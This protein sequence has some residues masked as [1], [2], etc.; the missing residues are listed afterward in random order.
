LGGALAAAALLLPCA[1]QAN[2]FYVAPT[3]SDTNTGNITAPFA[4]IMR[5]QTAASANDTVYLRGGNYT[6]NTA[7]VTTIQDS[8]Y[9][10]VNNITKN[11]IH[12]LAY[13]G[14]ARPVF[15]FSQVTPAGTR[16]AAF[17]VTASNITFQGFD[18]IGVQETITGSNNQSIG[19]AIFG[20]SNCTWN[21]VNVHDGMCV[22]FYVEKASANNLFYQCDSYNN[23][24]LDSFSYGNADGFGCHPSAGGTGNVFRQC[25]SWN[26]SDDGYDCINAAEP[27]TFDHCWSYLNGNNGGNANGFKVGGWGSTVQSSIPNPLPAH[28]VKYCLSANNGSHGF[29]ANHQPGQAATWTYNTAFN[30]NYDFDML[31]RTAPIYT[32]STAQTDSNDISG[33][34][35]IMHYNLA[36]EG[37]GGLTNDLNESGAI[38]SNN[39][40]T[41]S[42]TVNSAQFQSVDPTQMTLPRQADGSLPVLT[43][44]HLVSGSNCAG[45]GCFESAPL[46]LNATVSNGQV[47]LTWTSVLGAMAYVVNRSTTSGGNYTAIS[48]NL[49]SGNYTDTTAASGTKYYYVVT[50]SNGEDTSPNSTEVNATPLAAPTGVTA[51]PGNANVTL[52]WTAST[53]ASNYTVQRSTTNGSGYTTLVTGVSATT[54]KDS[55]AANGTT[56]YYIVVAINV[57]GSSGNSTQASGTAQPPAPAA[58]TG[59]IVTPGN[60]NVT[61]NWTASSGASNYTVERST[62][63]GSGYTTLA[64]G[65]SA[66]TY[67]DTTVANGTTYYYVVVAANAGG[68]SG[69]ST[70]ASAT[71]LPP[72]PSAPTGLAAAPGNATVGLTWAASSGAT[73]YIVQRSSTSGSGYAIINGTVATASFTDTGLTNGNTYYYVVAAANIGGTSANSAQVSAT[74]TQTL[75]QWTSTAFPG[76]SDPAIIGPTANPSGDGIPNLLKYF[77]GLDPALTATNPPVT[78]SDDNSSDVVLTFRLSKNLTGVTYQIQQSTNLSSWS[79]TGLQGTVV[80]DQGTYYLMQAVV[81]MGANPSLYLRVSVTQGG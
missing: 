33:V 12:Y 8:V 53:G 26:N 73:S 69:T 59:L 5:A 13:P 28:I 66:T 63:N 70:Q 81:P 57:N 17:W 52:N 78:S 50:A 11:G 34:A 76:Q 32:N 29:Y 10:V 54:Y 25:R 20:G 18:V 55:T 2:T 56:Y 71:P 44:M 37:S 14:D 60:G 7:N 19:F 39:T 62:T 4:T 9:S 16:N 48:G 79:D 1:A 67:Q 61:L 80:S 43:F 47:S 72:A 31:E 42:V 27:V 23:T 46:G 45:L 15:S 64:T 21:Q 30:D 65:V 68:S 75:T 74:P 51:T 40:W 38:V 22:G 41:L 6:L 24:G 3:G 58:P 35:E 77:F 36:Y 49:T